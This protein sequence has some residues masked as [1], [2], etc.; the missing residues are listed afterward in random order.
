M[1]K[2][3][4]IEF[5]NKIEDDPE[6]YI[7]AYIEFRSYI[8]EAKTVVYSIESEQKEGKIIIKNF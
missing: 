7:E 3:K 4:L 1:R 2:S 8:D 6:V 5:L